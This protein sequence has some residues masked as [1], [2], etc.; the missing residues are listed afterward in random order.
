MPQISVNGKETEVSENFTINDILNDL[1]VKNSLF[2]V[3]KN[4]EI[5]DKDQY[6]STVQDGDSF[7]VVSLF[8]GQNNFLKSLI[9]M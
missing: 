6:K 4:L 7:E 3:E 9:K 1:K 5:I 2:V 8:G